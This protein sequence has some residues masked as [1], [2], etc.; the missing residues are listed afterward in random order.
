MTKVLV[1][2]S[3]GLI[4][5]QVTHDLIKE[6]FDVY[7][8]YNNEK[9]EFGIPTYLNLS[10]S[11]GIV[12]VLYSVKP[13]IIIHLAAITDVDLCETQRD[14]AYLVNTKATQVLARESNKYNSFFVYMSTDYIFDG[15]NG[16]KNETDKPNPI[17]FYGKSKLDGELA[18]SDSSSIIRTSTPFG[19]HAKKKSFPLWIKENLES[20]KE[21]PVLVDQFT[22]PTFVPNLSK[23]LIEVAIK[24]IRGIIHLTGSTRISRYEFARLIADKFSLDSSFLKPSKISE[25]KWIAQRPQDS[26]LN[27]SKAIQILDNK[28]QT[29]ENSLENFLNQL[30]NLNQDYQQS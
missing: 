6:N 3:A 28:P 16:M 8:C 20:K 25:M 18:L 4:G 9:P 22:S 29:I 13:E 7:S 2:G 5:R 15:K 11:D 23:M 26:S 12:T 27:I 24:Q 14:P 17:N 1:T 21:I 19:L 10:K 30:K